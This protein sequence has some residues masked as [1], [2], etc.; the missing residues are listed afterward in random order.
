[1]TP[2]QLS[3]LTVNDLAIEAVNSWKLGLITTVTAASLL[4]QALGEL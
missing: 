4:K 3:K 2:E 1:M